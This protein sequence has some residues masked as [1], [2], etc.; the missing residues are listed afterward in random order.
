[1]TEL[2]TLAR[3]YAEAVFKRA[4]ES[5]RLDEWSKMLD[6]LATAMAD[7][8]L[9]AMAVDPN[10]K[11]ETLLRILLD[12]GKGY[13]DKE[14]ENFVRI[15]VLNGR[16]TL[17]PQIRELFERYL[18]EH[19]DII[20]VEVTTAYPL[21]EE[22]QARLVQALQRNLGKRVRLDVKEDHQ[23]IGGVRI[24]AGDKVMDGSVRGQLERL[25]KRLYS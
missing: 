18:A 15:L 25:A 10:V 22:D 17:L 3:P 5:D 23:L 20:D 14:G 1:M 12:I 19:Q 4:L 24:R 11:R 13:L 7:R 16:V 6:F 2:V 9:A 21:T 8:E